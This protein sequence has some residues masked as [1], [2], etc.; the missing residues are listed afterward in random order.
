MKRRSKTVD[1]DDAPEATAAFFRRAVRLEDAPAAVRDSIIAFQKRARG[2]QKAPTKT[3]I[4]LRIQRDTIAR[5][6]ATGRGW[7]ARMDADLAKAAKRRAR[8]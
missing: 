1:P 5:Y 3:L 4:T 8:A 2:P 7:Q 6:R